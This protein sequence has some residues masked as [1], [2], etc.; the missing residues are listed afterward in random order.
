MCIRDSATP[1]P[2]VATPAAEERAHLSSDGKW[3]A[4]TSDESGRR[5]IYAM[6]FPDSAS[7]RQIT[8]GGGDHP[9]YSPDGKSLYYRSPSGTLMRFSL[10]DNGMPSDKASVHYARPFGQSDPLAR[11]FTVA[12]DGRV[13]VV[14]ASER[15]VQTTHIRA[16]TRWYDLIPAPAEPKR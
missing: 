13:L 3:L 2:L 10:G 12:P 7:R 8:N 14:E 9:I 15:R 16:V 5:E 6:S 11:D 4:Y 1:K